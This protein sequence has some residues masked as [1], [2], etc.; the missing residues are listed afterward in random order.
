MFNI[1]MTVVAQRSQ[2]GIWFELNQSN[3]LDYLWKITLPAR[4]VGEPWVCG[5][6]DRAKEPEGFEARFRRA[7][8]HE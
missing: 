7:T 3:C 1:Q 5:L 6:E 8:A 4:D 2:L